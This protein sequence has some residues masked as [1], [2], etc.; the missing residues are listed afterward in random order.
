M[1]SPLNALRTLNIQVLTLAAGSALAQITGAAIYIFT[2]RSMRPEDYGSVITAIGLGIACAG[3]LDLGTNGY[4]IR[5]L[6]SSR[7]SLKELGP[8]ISTRIMIVV[9][10]GCSIALAA[11]FVSPAFVPTGF[12]LI[13]TSASQLA[14][15]PLKAARRSEKVGWLIA[16]GRVLAIAIFFGQISIGFDP[17]TALWTSLALG[18][19]ALAILAMA[20][21][22]KGHRPRFCVVPISNPWT[23]SRWYAINSL[24]LSA[25]PLDLPL[26]AA[27]SGPVAAGIYGGVNRWTQPLLATIG[28][29]NAA[30]APFI[31]AET[32]LEKLKPQLVRA[33]WVLILAASMSV[34]VII[35]APWMV[36]FLLGQAYDDSVPILRLMALSMMLN[37]IT[38]PLLVAM[39]S[40]NLDHLAALIV[41]IAIATHLLTIATLAPAFGALAAG[42]GALATQVV[43][44][45]G[46]VGG[47]MVI[48]RRRQ[49]A[50]RSRP[51]QLD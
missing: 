12:I 39:Q 3:F 10:V 21:T 28:A 18:D 26:L 33:S 23:G 44:L 27:I 32:R 34:A 16:L 29:F 2:A 47:L 14:Q 51:T 42:L 4:W 20:V 22:P 46:A 49:F 25:Q 41:A 13:T 37:T 35:L 6:A 30:A 5:E 24:S 15:V 11:A 8:R 43:A 40:R 9:S 50:R 1:V 38:S 36:P 7:I 48:H 31:A 19:L 17:G 45:I